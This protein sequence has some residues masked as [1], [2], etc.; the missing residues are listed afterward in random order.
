[1][2]EDPVMSEFSTKL[3]ELVAE[4]V[5]AENDCDRDRAD[6][7]LAASFLGITRARGVEQNREQLLDQIAHCPNNLV[8]TLEESSATT[9]ASE[10]FAVVRSIVGVNDSVGTPQGRYRNLHAFERQNQQWICVAWQVTKL[11]PEDA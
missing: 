6:R 8:R 11:E 3:R 9:Y 4:L 7:V 10:A 1:M 2:I 5:A